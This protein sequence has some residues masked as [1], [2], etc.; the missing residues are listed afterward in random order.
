MAQTQKPPLGPTNSNT[1]A[2]K[3]VWNEKCDRT[4]VSV[5]VQAKREGLSANNGFKTVVWRRAE[6][7][8]VGIEATS[9]GA[10]KS[11]TACTT[12]FT[13]VSITLFIL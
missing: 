8:L 3:T 11:A 7:A 6:K 5:L 10:A 2:P 1:R 12:R 9:G 13:A 4:L